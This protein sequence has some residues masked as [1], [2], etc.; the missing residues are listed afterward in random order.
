MAKKMVGQDA[1]NVI[2]KYLKQTAMQDDMIDDNHL[3][4]KSSFSSVKIS[5][6]VQ[7]SKIYAND[8]FED[9]NGKSAYELAVEAGFEG[10]QESWLASL[11]GKDGTSVANIKGKVAI[12]SELTGLTGLSNGDGYMV[13]AT[14]NLHVFIDGAFVNLGKIQGPQGEK[15][16]RGL[17]G[18]KGEKGEV[19][20]FDKNVKFPE[21]LTNSKYIVNAI[22]ELYRLIN[23]IPEPEQAD[24]IYYGYFEWQKTA[25]QTDLGWVLTYDD[26]T[27][28]HILN[29]PYSVYTQIEDS[30]LTAENISISSNATIPALSMIYIAT[31]VSGGYKVFL[32][33]EVSTDVS[34]FPI[35]T[36]LGA[37]GEYTLEINGIEYQ[38]WGMPAFD[39]A[40][41]IY[42]RIEK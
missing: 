39:G 11:K 41:K 33:N 3:S 19:G 10:S 40:G 36:N 42:I 6:L 34:A 26:I 18:E 8:L 31:P 23:N 30:Q 5:E 2:A 37:N 24:I 7:A 16:E 14:G 35:D 13:V 32:A 17:Q 22:N 9:V 27:Q 38:I 15:G 1:L 20:T 28:D 25:E 29:N 21:L 12:E 4:T